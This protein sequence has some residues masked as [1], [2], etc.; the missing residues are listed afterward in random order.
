MKRTAGILAA[1]LST[2]ALLGQQPTSVP[3]P[4]A[5]PVAASTTPGPLQ[6][7]E[8]VA[9]D[10]ATRDQL[11]NA[12]LAWFTEA[13]KSGK[14]VLQVQNREGGTLIGTGVAQYEPVV[15][16]AS[17][18][19]RGVL[20]YRVTVEGKDGRYRYTFD[21]FTHEG[22]TSACKSEGI[23]FGL[24]TT[25]RLPPPQVGKLKFFG[26]LPDSG[27]IELWNDLKQKA[28]AIAERLTKSLRAKLAV[29]ANEKPW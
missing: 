25:D 7:Q 28:T 24:L 4:A 1:F 11:Y 18:C 21:G 2:G 8:V 17:S 13:F 19:T 20:R 23:S 22:G 3:T 15:L 10:G 16:M 5:T 14:D 6:F 27:R 29:A 26:G 12:A 9:V